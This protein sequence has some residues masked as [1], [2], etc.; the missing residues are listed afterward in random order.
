MKAFIYRFSPGFLCLL[1]ERVEASPLG[2]RLAKGA[3]WSLAGSL[4]S[5]GLGLLSAILVGRML[6]KHGFGELGMIQNTVGLFGTVAG[7]GM[8]M[9]ATKHVAEFRISDPERAGRIIAMASATTWAT[10]VVMGL[11]LVVFA[12]WLAERTLAAPQ[13]ADLLRVGALLLILGGVNGAQT[14]AL[15]GFEAFKT[16]SRINL[17]SGLLS[18]PMM[19]IGAWY[20]GVTGA[21]WGLVGSNGINCALNNIAL[22][23]EISRAKITLNFSHCFRETGV[24]WNFNLPTVADGLLNGLVT[25]GCSA[26]L[27]HQLSGYSDM[28]AYNAVLRVKLLPEAVFGVLVAPL[29]PVL[30]DSIGRSDYKGFHQAAHYSFALGIFLLVPISL[31]QMTAPGLTLLPF[32]KAFE[33]SQPIVEWMMAH[34]ILKALLGPVGSIVTSGGKLWFAL[35]V[36]ALYAV[37]SMLLAWWLVPLYRGAGM[38]AA[39][40][41][42]FAAAN[43]LLI[44]FLFRTYPSL[45]ASLR[46]W[47]LFVGIMV[48]AVL[49]VWSAAHMSFLLSILAGFLITLVFVLWQAW[50]QGRSIILGLEV[51]KH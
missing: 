40:T 18:F 13:L 37:L 15:A 3:F 9:T 14:G 25:W 32:G 12:P 27:A 43:S 16:I 11:A 36:N 31:L 33:G 17:I 7:F 38:A 42:A 41:V 49:A 46:W 48:L 8:G 51:V 30:S 39:Q 35:S 23:E 20:W 44:C 50:L 22:R 21:T 6:G 29:L 34:S 19:V 1:Y 4:I 2:Y 47:S 45:M 28:G 5:R 26:I 10:S 24:L